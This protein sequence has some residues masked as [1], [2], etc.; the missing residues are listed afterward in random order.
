MYNAEMTARI[1]AWRAKAAD[2]T[3]T[4]EEMKEAIVALRQ[5]RFEAAPK[6]K[7]PKAPKKTA[8]QSGDDLLS[9]FGL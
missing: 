9:E 6:P 8:A 3:I 1:A 4:I 5:S 7:E 2:N